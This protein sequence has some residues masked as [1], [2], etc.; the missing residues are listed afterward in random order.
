MT[1]RSGSN[2]RRRSA[3]GAMALLVA[4]SACAST[5]PPT[6]TSPL[7][8]RRATVD[9]PDA[10]PD[11]PEN[12]PTAVMLGAAL[13]ESGNVR[14]ALAYYRFA[15][16]STPEDA[17]IGRRFVEV[18][19]RAGRAD[20]ALEALDVLVA[21]EP[22]AADLA[23]QRAEL[24]ALTGQADQAL[25]AIDA[26]LVD[27]PDDDYAQQLRIDLLQDTGNT[28]EA[29]RAVDARIEADPDQAL[30]R[31]RRGDLL[32][33]LGRPGQAEQA[34]REALTL[35][36]ASVDA[37]DRFAELL[38]SQGRHDELVEV[39]E[40]LAARGALGVA[41]QLR[42]ADLLL[43]QGDREGAVEVLLPLT[44]R[45]ALDLRERRIVA[46]LLASLDRHEDALA[47]L[48]GAI[49]DGEDVPSE[50]VR[51]M[52]ELKMEL[53]DYDAAVELLARAVELDPDD[54]GAHVSLLLSMGQAEPGLFDGTASAELRRRYERSLDRAERAI[55][56]DS[57]RQ[58]FL[59]GALLRRADH[60][61]RAQ[62]FLERAA[63]LH[64]DN[65]QILYDLAI[66]QENNRDYDGARTTL[67]ALLALTPD[68]AHL[69]NFYGYLLADQGWELD[70][71][72]TLITEALEVEPENGAY[73]DSMGWVLF[74]LERYEEALDHLID[75]VNTLGD[76]PIV[77]E[78]LAECL[79]ALGRHEEALTTFQRAR[80]LAGDAAAHID[81]RIE[82]MRDALREG[83]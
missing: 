37:L 63:T 70:R 81:A 3:A 77:L 27:H 61:E 72:L 67:E 32:M 60:P 50:I 39:L 17:E 23:L 11:L 34:W 80:A 2:S 8:E 18:A 73:I 71:A 36:G 83:P 44:E 35:D 48:Q 78:H 56:E 5:A 47:V 10:P 74:R 82:A 40:D 1:M 53:E 55:D 42:L 46:D 59:L 65:E 41:Q 26:F 64:P 13:L 4:L 20:E 6:A 62:P 25:T 54:G 75:A 22:D 79:A 69:K 14:S 49:D 76:D 29:L 7:P 15:W 12:V 9:V 58:N 38:Q 28:I 43:A 33:E 52:G 16:D 21:R 19:L 45:G 66:V 31:V 57:V 30:W 68:D 24:L 51:S